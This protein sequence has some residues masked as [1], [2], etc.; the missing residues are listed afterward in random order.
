MRLTAHS[1]D[2]LLKYAISNAVIDQK[3]ITK[4]EVLSV[5]FFHSTGEFFAKKMGADYA[6]LKRQNALRKLERLRFQ[7]ETDKKDSGGNIRTKTFDVLIPQTAQEQ[8]I[9]IPCTVN[10]SRYSDAFYDIPKSL[11]NIAVKY[12]KQHELI[13]DLEREKRQMFSA[14]LKK[15]STFKKACEVFPP[16]ENAAHLVMANTAITASGVDLKEALSKFKVKSDVS[17]I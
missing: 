3:E 12:H 10:N 11:E 7:V 9:M 5:K 15:V 1:K 4:M 6:S 13:R 17:S 14:A 16:F 2:I 8:P